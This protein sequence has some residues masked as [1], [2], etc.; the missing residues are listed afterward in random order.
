MVAR[1]TLMT[2]LV[3]SLT[4]G[5]LGACATTT[6][7]ATPEDGPDGVVV[8]PRD[9]TPVTVKLPASEDFQLANGLR[10]RLVENHEVPLV[11][12]TVRIAGGSVEDPAGREGA[13]S[14]LA[15]LLTKGAG[16]HDAAAFQET[17]D[18]VGGMLTAA[19]GSR[20]ISVNAEFL[21]DDTDL[22]L[23]LLSDVLRRPHFNPQEFEK[24][25]GLAVDGLR[26]AREK[27][28]TLIAT[29]Y[30]GWMLGSHP[31]GRPSS[32]DEA[33]LGALTL[34]DVQGV[35]QRALVASRTILAVA[36]DFDPAAMRAKI[37]TTFGSWEAGTQPDALATPV[38]RAG[39]NV[40][41]VDK[42]DA[43]QTYFRFGNLG[44]DWSDPRYPARYL[45][46][47]I[48]GGRF[49]SRLNTALRIEGGLTYGAGSGFS[50]S[51]FGLFNV[52]SY[53][54]TPTSEECMDL[55]LEVYRTFQERGI[56]A[57]EL[58][59][60]RDYIQGQ[61]APDTVETAAQAAGMIVAL[62]SHGLPRTIVDEF[63]PAL[64]ALSLDE[65][66]AVI[67]DVFPLPARLS[68]VVIGQAD[69]LAPIV[70]RYG[71]VTRVPLA[72][73]GFAPLSR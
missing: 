19:A 14:I 68:W 18:F 61:F 52:R 24:E 42:P 8:L 50:D 47:T 13:T 16:E 15:E 45:A 39:G 53:T 70:A 27:P 6:K 11:T 37:E 33:S 12:L 31:L 4:L 57:A 63:F 73:P 17:V 23:G 25:R 51:N 10:V 32:G 66:N 36:G 30:G 22:A 71:T 2:A 44:V 35:A 29:Y 65:V 41:L 5:V 34:D 40:L 64:D 48:L 67:R 49:T 21:S 72:G 60:A 20:W 62:E 56:T 9:A 58:A 54:A 3:C 1:R 55:A 26:V 7:D 28:E 38:T 69:T 46:N 43:L 59:S